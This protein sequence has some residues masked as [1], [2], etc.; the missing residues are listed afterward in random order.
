M[1]QFERDKKYE[2][3]ERGD[4]TKR[5]LNENQYELIEEQIKRVRDGGRGQQYFIIS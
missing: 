2:N 4:Y 5:Q 1:W 3:V